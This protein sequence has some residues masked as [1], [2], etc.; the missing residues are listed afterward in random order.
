MEPIPNMELECG[1][2]EMA[3]APDSSS[4]ERKSGGTPKR[5]GRS[6]SKKAMREME[7]KREEELRARE[8][9]GTRARRDH[10][11]ALVKAK[12]PESEIVVSNCN[13]TFFDKNI[14]IE[15]VKD[16]LQHALGNTNKVSLASESCGGVKAPPL[17]IIQV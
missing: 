4:S 14:D 13:M 10:E 6:T 7:R 17:I 5:P 8:E 16:Y 11:V 2:V 9:M 3:P 12:G 15:V 1:E